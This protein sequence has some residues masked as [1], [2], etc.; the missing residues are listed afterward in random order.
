VAGPAGTATPGIETDQRAGPH[1]ED[2]SR[3][4]AENTFPTASVLSDAG[5][6]AAAE[7]PEGGNDSRQPPSIEQTFERKYDDL[8]PAE[9]ADQVIRFGYWLETQGRNLSPDEREH[10][11]AEYS[12][13]QDRLSIW[14][15]YDYK[16]AREHGYLLSAATKL[17]QGATN[18]GLVPVGHVPPSMLD[19][20]GTI[21]VFDN[22]PPAR[23]RPAAKPS[24][25]E[26]PATLVRPPAENGGLVGIVD[27]SVVGMIWNKD[28][29][30]QGSGRGGRGWPTYV[31]SQNPNATPLP[32][33]AK[34]FDFFIGPPGR[35]SA[36]KVCTRRQRFI[37]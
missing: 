31:A 7:A 30:L 12:F 11:L 29:K 10:A 23:L 26:P 2:H 27:N 8:G 14:L 1:V 18:S 5:H 37:S 22:L 13:L 34:G 35:R 17:Y 4:V 9:F 28:I 24:F 21:A 3:R 36:L 32:E 33:T 19:V 15:N 25:E 16:S 20:A 6:G